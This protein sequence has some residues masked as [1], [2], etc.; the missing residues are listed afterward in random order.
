MISP[1]SKWAPGSG[2]D[3]PGWPT[4]S[5]HTDAFAENAAVLDAGARK[6]HWSS[7][8][9]DSLRTAGDMRV[10]VYEAVDTQARLE[11]IDALLELPGTKP[12]SW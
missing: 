9:F 3:G 2:L 12:R 7:P 5:S 1:V 10:L 8:D 11:K 6:A 4:A